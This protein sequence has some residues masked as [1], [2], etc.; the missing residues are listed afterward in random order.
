MAN[1]FPRSKARIVLALTLH[2]FAIQS[3]AQELLT[4][5]ECKVLILEHN[6]RAAIA[7]AQIKISEESI[8]FNKANWLPS[9]S[10]N[11]MV[12][13]FTE[14][15]ILP[16]LATYSGITDVSLT[17]P[18]YTGGK[19]KALNDLA[20][21]DKAIAVEEKRLSEE[22]LIFQV[23]QLYW[24]VVSVEQQVVV[25]ENYERTLRQLGLKISNY[26]EAGL[27]NKTELLETQVAHNKAIY[28][29]EVARD[30]HQIARR[31]LAQAIDK[32]D[33]DFRIQAKFHEYM[34]SPMLTTDISTSYTLRPELA[35]S[36]SAI[37]AKEHERALIDSKYKPQVSL[38]AGTYYYAGENT[39]PE[40]RGS[41]QVFAAGMLSVSIPIHNWGKR[42][43]QQKINALET[44][45]LIEGKTVLKKRIS[46]EV[47]NAIFKM[48][49]A[50]INVD[51]TKKS[52]EQALEN[53]RIT[54]DNY[55]NGLITSEEVLEAESL[56]QQAQLDYIRAKVQE[57]LSYAGYLKTLGKLSKQ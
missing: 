14:S 28:N 40:I 41:D 16:G 48:N 46:L 8:Q 38:R 18:I 52:K 50:K 17:Q 55:N 49:E 27:V 21:V 47:E 12:L 37:L 39:M 43:N 54:N 26:Y 57:Q 33:T 2:L 29:L 23:E 3:F 42:K 32:K 25:A 5:E 31:Q 22:E 36:N 20:A 9:V 34:V 30:F 10:A 19:L 53:V 4:L 1:L 6:E 13:G 45:Q 35:I 44:Q 51:L 56:N 15:P 24:Q 7:Q 11:S